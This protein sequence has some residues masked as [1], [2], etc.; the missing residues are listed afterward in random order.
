MKPQGKTLNMFLLE[1]MHTE[2][3]TDSEEAAAMNFEEQQHSA[4]TGHSL[5]SCSFPTAGR[6]CFPELPFPAAADPGQCPRA[7]LSWGMLSPHTSQSRAPS[8]DLHT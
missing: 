6:S 5:S 2:L 4:I 7:V 3:K 1:L 8:T